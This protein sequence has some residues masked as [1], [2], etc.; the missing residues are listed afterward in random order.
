MGN[1]SSPAKAGDPVLQNLCY[2]S[3]NRGVLDTPL[4][5]FAGYDRELHRSAACGST[6]CLDGQIRDTAV[7]PSR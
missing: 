3:I 5:A 7:Q 2:E 1:S 4:S 6:G